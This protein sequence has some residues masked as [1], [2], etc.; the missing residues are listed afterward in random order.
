MQHLFR[1][2]DGE[3]LLYAWFSA[4]H[5]RVDIALVAS[6]DERHLLAIVEQMAAVIDE[7]E[8]KANCFNPQSELSLLSALGLRLCCLSQF[9][10]RMSPLLYDILCACADYKDQTSGLFDVEVEGRINLS[11]FVKGYALDMIRPVLERNSIAHAL[12][13]M[14]NSSVMALGNQPGST[15]GWSVKTAAGKV[16]QLRNQCLTTSGNDSVT[17]RHIIN[18]HTRQYVCG[19]CIESVVTSGGAEARLW[20]KCGCSRL[21][22][23]PARC[24]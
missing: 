21:S 8:Q 20:A 3:N 4:M 14:G 16:F 7:I 22:R 23:C 2:G 17:R 19:L 18:P 12:I 1:H 11:G 6:Q 15:D 5:T 9:R 13:N 10:Q 24:Q